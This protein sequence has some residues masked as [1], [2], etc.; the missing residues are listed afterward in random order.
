MRGG[1]V[2]VLVLIP[3][4]DVLINTGLMREDFH[5]SKRREGEPP[6][7]PNGEQKNLFG[8]ARVLTLHYSPLNKKILSG[9]EPTSAPKWEPEASSFPPNQI[10]A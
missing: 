5:R 4:W 7:M 2:L 6:N 8:V 3:C 10:C 1:A 9:P